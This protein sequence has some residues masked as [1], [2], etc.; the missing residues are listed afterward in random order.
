MKLDSP[1]RKHLK[2]GDFGISA[3][4]K[5]LKLSKYL[6]RNFSQPLPES[7]VDGKPWMPSLDLSQRSSRQEPEL[8]PEFS[9]NQVNGYF[10]FDN[11]GMQYHDTSYEGQRG[12]PNTLTWKEDSNAAHAQTVP[13]HIS[14]SSKRAHHR[15]LGEAVPQRYSNRNIALSSS[16][17]WSSPY[18]GSVSGHKDTAH[19]GKTGHL[20]PP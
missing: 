13:E 7:Q 17:D 5:W 3:A 10:R 15:G 8:F 6:E 9:N 1:H 14:K 4:N 12:N 19:D 11:P 2:S 16:W 20:Y 18:G